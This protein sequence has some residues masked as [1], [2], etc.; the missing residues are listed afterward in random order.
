MGKSS[1]N[2]KSALQS[3]QSRMKVKAKI[4]HAAQVTEQKARKQAGRSGGKNVQSSAASAGTSSISFTNNKGKGKAKPTVKIA[5][6]STT[7]RPTIPF[8]ATDKILLIGEGNF[9]FARSLIE[10]PPTELQSLPP[11]NVTATAFDTEEGCYAKYP[12]AEEIV[13]K[14]K[15]RGVN[16]FFGVDGT[17]LEKHPSLKGK[18]WDRIVWNFP[19]AGERNISF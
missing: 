12:D 6:K 3:Q 5:S 1:K 2:L 16:V 15:E 10:D 7:R 13:A 11:A 9:S 8:R 17:K 19:H 18:K 14:I 4:S